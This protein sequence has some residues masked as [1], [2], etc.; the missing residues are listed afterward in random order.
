MSDVRSLFLAQSIICLHDIKIYSPKKEE[1]Q[2][3]DPGPERYMDD[4]RGETQSR[5]LQEQPLS[6]VQLP[7]S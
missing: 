2:C 5:E 1:P 3:E 7:I 4:L 6:L